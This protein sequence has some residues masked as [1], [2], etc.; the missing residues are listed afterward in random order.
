M[1]TRSVMGSVILIVISSGFG[2]AASAKGLKFGIAGKSVDDAHFISVWAG[3]AKEAKR[4]G[5]VCLNIGF[6]GPANFHK[7]D[8]AISMAIDRGI[9]GL[10]VSVTN[11]ERLAQSSLRKAF[12]KKIPVVTF[13]SDMGESYAYLRKGYIGPDNVKLGGEMASIAMKLRPQG[14]SICLMSGDPH[15]TNLNQRLTGVRN[16]LS[17]KAS[18]PENK[19]LQGEGGWFEASRCPFFNLDQPSMAIAQMK[20]ALANEKADVFVSVG[21]WPVIDLDIY[22]SN[23]V[24]LKKINHEVDKKIII[25]GGGGKILPGQI[26][27]LHD[28][29]VQGFVSIDFEQMGRVVYSH[30]RRL[31]VGKSIPPLTYTKHSIYVGPGD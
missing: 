10:A 15:D 19:K 28:K 5:D 25:I 21:S 4:H 26:A 7:Q 16:A 11:S 20:T 18:F 9:D 13:D 30:L 8:G 6:P 31:A 22:R 23:L 1:K 29:L 2:A 3:C 24:D 12:I 17:G 27:L 14:G